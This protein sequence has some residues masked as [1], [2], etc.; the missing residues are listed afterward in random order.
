MQILLPKRKAI[1]VYLFVIVIISLFSVCSGPKI[2]EAKL[3]YAPEVPPHIDRTSESKVIVNMETIEVVGRLADGVEYTFWT[4]GGSVPGPMI[5][6]REGDEVEFHLKNHPSSKMP[7]NIDLHAVTGQGGGAAASLTI[8]GHASKFSFKALNPGLYIYHCATSPVGMHIA[9]GM[10]GLIF[11]QPKDD[12]PKVDKEYYVVQSEFYTK[13]KNGEPG[14]QPFSMEKAITEIPDYVVFNGSVGSLVEDRAI[15][16]KVGETVRLFVGNAGPNLVSSFHV[17]GEIFDHVYTEGG[18]LPNQKNVQTTLIPAGGSAIV[19]FKV[20]VPGTLILVDHSIFRTFN[21]GSLGMLKVEGE[22][23]ATIYSGKQDDTVYLP[24]GPAIQRM[25]TEVKP[26]VSAKT[27]KEILANGERVYKSVCA[28]C[29]MKE[30]Q[31]VVGV[32][33]PLAKS[34]YLNADKTRAIQ[35][36]KKGLS[37]PITVNGQK[38][39]NVMPH[40]ELTNEEIASVLSYVYN[41]WGN[42]GIMVSEAEVR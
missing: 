32:F 39:N 28:A 38:Y 27:P 42:K 10:Y 29:H 40:L 36:L 25:V 22:P 37:G 19:D 30:G 18:I 33:P 3:T 31:G 20:E 23:N 5:R 13:G 34:D 41:Q 6:V 4:F 12:L 16:A 11:V 15:T 21:K 1:T 26:K 14:L 17:I 2:E 7:H 8:P 24:E 9:N 35:I